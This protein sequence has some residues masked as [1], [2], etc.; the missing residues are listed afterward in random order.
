MV[1]TIF[2][3]LRVQE[4]LNIEKIAFYVLQMKF[5]AKHITNQKLSFDVF[6]V[7]ISSWDMILISNDFLHNKN[8]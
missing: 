4:N 1:W 2:E 6:T 7:G 8:A 5:L 3:N